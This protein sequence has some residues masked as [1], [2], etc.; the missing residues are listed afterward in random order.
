MRRRTRVDIIV[1]TYNAAGFMKKCFEAL[2]R[3]TKWP[4]NI[5]IADDCSDEEELRD[6]LLQLRA[7]RQARVLFSDTRRGFAGNNNWAAAQTRNPYICLLNEDTEPQHLWLTRMME[8]MYSD[9]KIGI[10][11]AKL[12]YPAGK[13]P[14]AYPGTIQHAGIARYA[15]GSPYHPFRGL[16]A[17]FPLANVVRDVNAVTGACML[18][19][20]RLWDELGGFDERYS[21]GQFEDCSLCWT[22]REKGWRI[23]MQPKAV[24]FHYEH[25]CG[26]EHVREGHDKNRK[27]LLEEWAHLGSDEDLFR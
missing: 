26:E 5:V 24:L 10:V 20:R 1:A 16:K 8:L 25:G 14:D 9:D 18:V 27:L 7:S 6:Y 13:E 17:D 22:A 21:M 12:L 19:R 2:R 15:D 11:G 23:M 3:N 4:C